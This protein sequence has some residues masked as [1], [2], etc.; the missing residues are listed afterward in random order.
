MNDFR[1]GYNRYRLD[2]VPINFATNGG[3]GNELG[4]PNSNVTPREQNLPIFSPAAYL[5]IGQTRS[6]PLYRRENTFQELDNLTWT[7][8]VHTFK[9]GADFRRRQL[10]IYQTNQ[11]NGRFNFSA[12]FT[13][14]RNPSAKGAMPQPALSSASQ[15]SMRTIMT[16]NSQE[17]GSTNSACISP[18]TVELRKTSRSTTVSVGTTSARRMKS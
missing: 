1:V 6:L 9:V 2:Y 13:D 5:G 4:V 10:T 8:G 16:I 11:G 17:F 14:S 3:L 12:A 15:R 18:T 7:K